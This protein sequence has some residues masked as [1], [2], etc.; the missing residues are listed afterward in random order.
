ML[1][2]FC[3]ALSPPPDEPD[4]GLVLFAAPLD[5]GLE[6]FV[7]DPGVADDFVEDDGEPVGD[8]EAFGLVDELPLGADGVVLAGAVAS[9]PVDAPGDEETVMT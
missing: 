9:P 5:F 2:V 4:L 7:E 1:R 3:S 6:A 8:D